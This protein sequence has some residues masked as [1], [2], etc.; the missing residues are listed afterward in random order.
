MDVQTDIIKMKFEFS[1][2]KNLIL[3]ETREIGFEEVIKAIKNG[4]IL[5]DLQNRNYPNQ[6]IIVV[7][8]KKYIYAVPYVYNKKTGRI[9]LKTVYPSRELTNKYLK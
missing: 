3:V 5:D 9:F 6:K 2:E 7:K 8:I 4:N 1:E